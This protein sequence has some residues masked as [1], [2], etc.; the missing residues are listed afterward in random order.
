MTIYRT[1]TALAVA[2]AAIGTGFAAA[3]PAAAG[4]IGD[5]LSPAFGTGCENHRIGA[6][7]TG[8]TTSG[9]G[10]ASSNTGRLPLLSALNRC[11]GADAPALMRINEGGDSYA[12]ASI[13]EI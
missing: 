8:A 10:T 6:H 9:S 1:A 4:G 5:F 12:Q 11:G 13:E 2:A 7:A 3:E